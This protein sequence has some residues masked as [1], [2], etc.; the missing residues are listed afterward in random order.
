M[1]PIELVL[2]ILSTAVFALAV[3]AAVL[4]A[5]LLGRGPL[6]RG[7]ARS[8]RWSANQSGD[9]FVNTRAAEESE[10][11]SHQTR[12]S[13]RLA[14]RMESSNSRKDELARRGLRP[15]E[16]ELDQILRGNFAA[17]I[18][19]RAVRIVVWSFILIVLL[20]VSV[21][22]LWQP[23][24]AQIVV[25]LT[26][27]GLFVVVM[28]ELMPPGHL[29]T[30]RVIV[31]GSAAV[32]FVTTLVLLTGNSASPF[33]LIYPLLVGGTAL[34]APP[35]VPLL[36]TVEKA[37]AYALAVLSGPA[38]AA[39]TP[40]TL[41]R[42]GINLTVLMLLTYSGMVVAR[43]QHRTR[44]AAIRLSTVDSLTD[45]YNRAFF[46]NA[47]DQEIHRSRRFQRGFCLLMMD[48]DGLKAI[49]DRYG[50]YEGDVVLR[51]IAQLI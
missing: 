9:D 44:E 27:G 16:D 7:S 11:P 13:R 24:E 41:A 38:G 21:G 33:F 14:I 18:Y 4:A 45:L 39:T 2:G 42:I 50:H 31:E 37:A 32:A 36:L 19:N 48:L 34:I 5:A 49:N 46:F 20:I 12:A 17:E 8:D 1:I 6:V 28:H 15:S 51:E 30:L 25:T 23:E 29:G 10:A 3:T 40:D 26:L 47:I 43:V 35:V 22:K